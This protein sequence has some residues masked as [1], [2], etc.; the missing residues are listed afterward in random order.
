MNEAL[1]MFEHLVLCAIVCVEPKAY[2]T[3]IADA[4]ERATGR[5]VSPGALYTT[6]ER[7]EKKSTVTSGLGE[8]TAVR[9]GRAKRFYHATAAARAA[10]RATQRSLHLLLEN[11]CLEEESC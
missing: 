1:G 3:S 10:L 8:P 5:A 7:L 9:G 4:L 11:V 2:G 6:L